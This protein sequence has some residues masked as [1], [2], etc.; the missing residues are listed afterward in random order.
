MPLLFGAYLELASKFCEDISLDFCRSRV[1]TTGQ[2]FV[3]TDPVHIA[4]CS[5]LGWESSQH[6][7]LEENHGSLSATRHF[8]DILL[9]TKWIRRSNTAP[10]DYT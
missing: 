4:H 8:H 3:R 6:V 5:S 2:T 10:A 7:D 1:V 9:T